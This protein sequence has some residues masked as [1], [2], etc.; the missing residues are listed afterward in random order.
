MKQK[1]RPLADRIL[2]QPFVMDETTE[3]GIIVPE[4][5]RDKQRKGKV[6][7]VGPGTS[8]VKMT[9]K[10]GD[11]ILYGQYAPTELRVDTTDYVIMR[12]ENVLAI[13]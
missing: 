11:T 1:I 13:L 12:M 6:V 7:A 5:Y 2:V 9:V 4:A 10:E 3:G 8:R